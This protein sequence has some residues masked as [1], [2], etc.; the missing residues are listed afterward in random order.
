MVVLIHGGYW[1][2]QYTKR[3]M[4]RMATAV[5]DEG[6]AAWNIEYRRIGRFGGGGGWPTTFA[7]VAD[8]VDAL[9]RVPGVDLGRVVTCGHSAGGQLALWAAARHRLGAGTVGASPKVRPRGAV[10]LAGVVDLRR[11]ADL[12]LG[13]GVVP[14][15]LGGGPDRVPERYA[16]VSP[17]AL[18]PLGVGQVLVHGLDDE[19][20]PPDMSERYVADAVAAGDT[21]TTYVPVDGVD[22]MAVINPASA[23]WPPIRDAIERLLGP[24]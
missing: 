17:A 2:A 13:A 23:A 22:H 20:V 16:A 6:W 12:G 8:A 14:E 4:R 10:S 7:D 9:T 21:D 18:L 24:P 15:L 19:T 5:T 11:A 3:L 1:R